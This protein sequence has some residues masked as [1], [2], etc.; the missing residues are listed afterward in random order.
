MSLRLVA[1]SRGTYRIFAGTAERHNAFGCLSPF[2]S[3]V[4]FSYQR[5]VEQYLMPPRT[6]KKKSLCIRSYE[7]ADQ[8]MPAID[9]NEE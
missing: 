4:C 3:A 8:K 7:T 6:D 5:S 1:E 2:Q 9:E